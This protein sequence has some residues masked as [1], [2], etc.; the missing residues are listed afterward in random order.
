MARSIIKGLEY[1]PLDL[2]FWQDRKLLKLR[3]QCGLEGP[4]IYLVILCAI[5]KEGYYVKWDE[6][7]D[8]D[9]AELLHA[10]EQHVS[11]V[12]D[13]CLNV[14]LFSRPM[15]EAHR[16]LTSYGIQR[17]YNM[18]T[19]RSKRKGCVTEYNLLISSEE[20]G[21]NSEETPISSEE[22][23]INS[24]ETPISSEEKGINSD[25]FKRKKEKKE[26]NKKENFIKEKIISEF[27]AKN[28]K[29]PN[30]EYQKLVD[31][32]SQPKVQTK[33]DDMAAEERLAVARLWQQQ[34]QQPP[35]FEPSF[36][37]TWSN[38]YVQLVQNDAPVEV[39]MQAL[40][41]KLRCTVDG[42]SLVLFMQPQLMQY[43]EDNIDLFRDNFQQE[44]SRK[45][46]SRIK[47]A[48]K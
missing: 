35:R 1:I 34:P 4:M 21:I 45:G 28:W 25:S 9:I 19:E 31:Y 37:M 44:M 22:K 16:I 30:K 43:I 27:T 10:E 47:Y 48:I 38:M 14:D 15:F 29:S 40:S 17:R 20:K 2:D 12:I 3:R 39:R 36:L 7:F 23:G 41:D 42:G 33:W 32:Y 24:E 8:F 11:E 6:D 26:I 5:Y 13:V 18:V 46:C